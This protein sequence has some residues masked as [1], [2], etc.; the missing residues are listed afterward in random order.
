MTMVGAGLLMAAAAVTGADHR[1]ASQRTAAHTDTSMSLELTLVTHLDM[2]LPEQDV[3]IEREAGSG[4]VWRVTGGDNDMSAPL[5]K[6]AVPVKHDP[7]NPDAVGPHPKGE[8][9]GLTLGQ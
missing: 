3:F 7:F 4:E 6:T 8:P 2:E 9:L 1:P 5:F